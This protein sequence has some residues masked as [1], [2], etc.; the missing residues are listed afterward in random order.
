MGLW[1]PRAGFD[2]QWRHSSK[3][4]WVRQTALYTFAFFS[5]LFF[6]YLFL[7][8]YLNWKL[9]LR[10]RSAHL[11]TLYF[12]PTCPCHEPYLIL[13]I[14]YF[15]RFSQM[16]TWLWSITDPADLIFDLVLMVFKRYF[17]RPSRVKFLELLGFRMVSKRYDFNKPW[18]TQLR[19]ALR[20]K[21]ISIFNY[22]LFLFLK[23]IFTWGNIP[24]RHPV[25]NRSFLKDGNP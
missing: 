2:S 24:A 7:L 6:V 15:S 13:V 19:S 22:Y 20:D 4:A 16:S 18:R 25:F 10:A 21:N 12:A 8:S 17:K 1:L 3:D 14:G 11:Y 5:I 9:V 23:E